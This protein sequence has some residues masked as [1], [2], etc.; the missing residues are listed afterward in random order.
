MDCSRFNQLCS[1]SLDSK[2]GIM[3][4]N[5]RSKSERDAI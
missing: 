3:V 5:V 4:A 1:D 2:K